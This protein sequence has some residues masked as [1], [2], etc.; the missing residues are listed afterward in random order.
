MPKALRKFR[1]YH[2]Y[3]REVG[4]KRCWEGSMH[5]FHLCGAQLDASH[6]KLHG[7]KW[8]VETWRKFKHVG[9]PLSGLKAAGWRQRAEGRPVNRSWTNPPQKIFPRYGPETRK[10]VL[11]F[12][13][14]YVQ[15]LFSRFHEII[16]YDLKLDEHIRELVLLQNIACSFKEFHEQDF[17]TPLDSNKT[18]LNCI[19]ALSNTHNHNSYI[20]LCTYLSHFKWRYCAT[21][22]LNIFNKFSIEAWSK[23]VSSSDI[24]CQTVGNGTAI[25]CRTGTPER[26]QRNSRNL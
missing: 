24:L 17:L 2:F 25:I 18:S 26:K 9:C 5:S 20:L 14:F 13:N 22:I 15:F 19:E 3:R 23:I 6:C 7:C 21:K 12:T 1:T 16:C 8:C 10:K 11:R 4:L